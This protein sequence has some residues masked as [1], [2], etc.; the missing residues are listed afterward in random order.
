LLLVCLVITDLLYVYDS[1]M[2][3]FIDEMLLNFSNIFSCML[4][5]VAF[6]MIVDSGV[7]HGVTS[8]QA[9]LLVFTV[10][11]SSLRTDAVPVNVL[12]GS[13]LVKTAWCWFFNIS[14]F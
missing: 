10:I 8:A 3:E 12:D 5:L 13:N 14:A 11:S 9:Q 1:V 7:L 4:C 2:F 6:R